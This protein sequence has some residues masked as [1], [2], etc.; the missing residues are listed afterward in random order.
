[1]PELEL[2]FGVSAA[3]NGAIQIAVVITAAVALVVVGRWLIP[4]LIATR[5][6]L[7]R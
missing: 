4:R 3:V 6:P 1:M 5:M 2:D 7:P